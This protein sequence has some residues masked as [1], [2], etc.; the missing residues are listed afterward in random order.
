MQQSRT[1]CATKREEGM[2]SEVFVFTPELINTLPEPYRQAMYLH[3][4]EKY[5]Y[6]AIAQQLHQPSGTVKSHV[7]RG[8]ER[9]RHRKRLNALQ[10]HT[11]FR[12]KER[13][14]I[15]ITQERIET[16]KEPYRTVVQLHYWVH[17]SYSSIAILLHLPVG[18]VKSY[19]HRGL[20]QLK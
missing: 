13:S 1:A 17:L 20:K 7:N 10:T 16:L 3:Y 5:S 12:H 19:Y 8:I 4:I 14:R 6:A 2:V 15:P 18:T 11:H 9:L